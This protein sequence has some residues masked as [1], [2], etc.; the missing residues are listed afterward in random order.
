VVA[1]VDMHFP[2]VDAHLKGAA[3][4]KAGA[5]LKGAATLTADAI[6]MAG[7]GATLGRD[8]TARVGA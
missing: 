5:D 1:A 3:D 8:I 6:T 7:A 2:A 4:F